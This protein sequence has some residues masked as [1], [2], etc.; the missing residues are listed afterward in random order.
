[1]CFQKIREGGGGGVKK[2]TS[3]WGGVLIE[4]TLKIFN[5]RLMWPWVMKLLVD[6]YLDIWIRGLCKK[7]GHY[8]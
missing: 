8:S 6:I 7:V 4:M 3:S 2:V 1:M 5:T